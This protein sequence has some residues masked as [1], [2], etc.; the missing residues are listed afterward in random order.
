MKIYG[1][2]KFIIGTGM[3]ILAVLLVFTTVLSGRIRM[4]SLLCGAAF[5][6]IGI[7]AI[8][9]SSGKGKSCSGCESAE[10]EAEAA[11]AVLFIM[12]LCCIAAVAVAVMVYTLV[13]RY[14]DEC[15][16]IMLTTGIMLAVSFL[17]EW[18]FESLFRKRK[19]RDKK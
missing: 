17:M 19:M 5:I 15:K 12:Q 6:V 1:R 16:G 10:A 3:L 18:A 7:N 11:K 8:C 13:D 2:K 4:I 9:A 14:S